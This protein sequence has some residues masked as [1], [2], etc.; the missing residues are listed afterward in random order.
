MAYTKPLV[1]PCE[2]LGCPKRAVIEVFHW[3]NY[4]FGRFCR[5]HALLKL[6]ELERLEAARAAIAQAKQP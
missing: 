6:A 4:S 2:S 5:R 3:Q 1:N